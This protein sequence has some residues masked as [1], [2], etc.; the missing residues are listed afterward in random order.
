MG[1]AKRF[2]HVAIGAVGSGTCPVEES[3]DRRQVRLC[4]A[5]ACNATMLAAKCAEKMDIILVI[6]SS[7]SVGASNFA[8]VQQFL[9][10]VIPRLSL[11]DDGV[12]LGAVQFGAAAAELAA[13]TTEPAKVTG[14][15]SGASWM[16]TSTNTAEALVKAE[17]S[18]LAGRQGVPKAIV[19]VT[20]GM[21]QSSYL[22]STVVDRLKKEGTRVLI[23]AVGS[24]VA[25][26]S[27]S[28]WASWPRSDN[29][30]QVPTYQDLNSDATL[31]Q[32]I[33][34]L[35]QEVDTSA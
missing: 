29:F 30:I 20:D 35:C 23:A 31:S 34:S 17:Q 9:G 26:G 12:M 15:I 25:V 6:D 11:G 24:E 2:K 3:D 16:K 22:A 10:K 27:I 1:H 13:L 32:L 14:P 28:S 33:L 21:A 18:F 5:Q 4:N 8:L 19:L 7:G